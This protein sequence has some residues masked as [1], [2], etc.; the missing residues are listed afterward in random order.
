MHGC[1]FSQIVIIVLTLIQVLNFG[2]YSSASDVWSFGI[3]TWEI[4]SLGETPYPHMTDKQVG[5][6]V[7]YMNA[8]LLQ[9]DK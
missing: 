3:L 7:S 8:I 2:K 6:Q 1:L 4:F 5:Q 9:Y